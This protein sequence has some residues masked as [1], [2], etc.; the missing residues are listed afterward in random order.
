MILIFGFYLSYQ[1]LDFFIN[2]FLILGEKDILALKE[3]KNQLKDNEICLGQNQMGLYYGGI[4]MGYLRKNIYF[5]PKCLEDES[6]LKNLKLAIVFHPQL[7]QFYLDEVNKFVVKGFKLI[8]CADL[9]CFL[10]K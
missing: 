2:K 5:S 3:L 1:K 8:G 6:K 4:A 10:E 7:G 9:W